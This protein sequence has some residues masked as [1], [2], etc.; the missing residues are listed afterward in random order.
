MQANQKENLYASIS[1]YLKDLGT[2]V[3]PKS[4]KLKDYKVSES[5]LMKENQL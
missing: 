2:N 4:V 1:A 5:L 3:K